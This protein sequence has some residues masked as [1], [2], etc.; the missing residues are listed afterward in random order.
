MSNIKAYGETQEELDV[1]DRVKCR[2]I[3]NEIMKFG[4]NQS[5]I[6]QIMYL[7][8]L[9][10]ENREIMIHLQKECKDAMNGKINKGSS[11]IV[12]N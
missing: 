10:L 4:V 9:E 6:L 11:L 5:Q 8:S 2:E 7:L 3:V 12:N 1:K